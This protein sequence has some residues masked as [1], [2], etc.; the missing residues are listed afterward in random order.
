MRRGILTG[1]A[2]ALAVLA[3]GSTRAAACD[4]DCDRCDG[5]GYYAAPA[6]Y[7][8][9]AF[10]YAPPV[11]YAAPAYAYYAPPP[12]YARPA[13]YAP[14]Y[15]YPYAQP[16]YLGRGGYV[17]AGRNDPRKGRVAADKPAGRGPYAF[18]ANPG[19]GGIKAPGSNSNPAKVSGFAAKQKKL[20]IT[21]TPAS[22]GTQAK[23]VPTAYYGGPGGNV[24]ARR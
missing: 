22:Y 21:A 11:Y 19:L 6:Y 5:Y 24:G 4:D 2:L 9:P 18:A 23:Y 7:V 17:D 14:A 1:S 10:A 13:Y 3:L 8:R 20:G 12:Y 15:G 16:S